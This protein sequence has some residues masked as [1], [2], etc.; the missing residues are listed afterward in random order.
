MLRSLCIPETPLALLGGALLHKSLEREINGISTPTARVQCT[1]YRGG[2]DVATWGLMH[3]DPP[4]IHGTPLALL[5]GAL[6]H[7]R[8]GVFGKRD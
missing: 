5:G 2:S 4:C 6:L 1:L 3:V 7:K 8:G